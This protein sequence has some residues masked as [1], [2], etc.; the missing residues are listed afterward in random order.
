MKNLIAESFRPQL[1]IVRVIYNHIAYLNEVKNLFAKNN[2]GS[3]CKDITEYI[4]NY[5]NLYKE[6]FFSVLEN[7]VGEYNNFVYK[8][9]ELLY[10]YQIKLYEE[11]SNENVDITRKNKDLLKNLREECLRIKEKTLNDE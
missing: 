7:T 5:L 9:L 4:G 11:G 8:D 6:T 10:M 1:H 3:M 2:M